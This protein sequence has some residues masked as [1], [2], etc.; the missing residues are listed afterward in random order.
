M[1]YLSLWPSKLKSWVRLKLLVFSNSNVL[2]IRTVV[3]PKVMVRLKLEYSLNLGF[4][5]HTY[6]PKLTQRLQPGLLSE[7]RESACGVR[8]NHR[9]KGY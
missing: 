2:K 5:L 9:A 7:L 8:H 4:Y 3:N 6:M 1:F